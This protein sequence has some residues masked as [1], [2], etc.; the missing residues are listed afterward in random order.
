MAR[1]ERGDDALKLR[2]DLGEDGAVLSKVYSSAEAVVKEDEVTNL[3]DELQVLRHD[4]DDLVVV[5]DAAG[6]PFELVREEVV[7]LD[8]AELGLRA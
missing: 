7:E 4:V 6:L 1:L 8:L 5:L 3:L 2:L